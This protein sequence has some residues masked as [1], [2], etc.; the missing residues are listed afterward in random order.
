MFELVRN[1][2]YLYVVG[3]VIVIGCKMVV[4]VVGDKCKWFCK[5]WYWW[6]YVVVC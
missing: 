3:G 4:V 2:R 1:I 6:W 5:W